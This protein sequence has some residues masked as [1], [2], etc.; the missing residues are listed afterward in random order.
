MQSVQKMSRDIQKFLELQKEL[1]L[2]EKKRLEQL[3]T[4][5]PQV[6]KKTSLTTEVP[7]IISRNKI[8]KSLRLHSPKY[9]RKSFVT[10]TFTHFRLFLK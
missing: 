7:F 8:M 4:T 9:F 2:A 6:K 3:Q 10:F 1:I 5:Q